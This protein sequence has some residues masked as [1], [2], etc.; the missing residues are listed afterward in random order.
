MHVNSLRAF[1]VTDAHS[2][3]CSSCC[4]VAFEYVR[5][6]GV[7][8][9]RLLRLPQNRGKVGHFWLWPNILRVCLKAST[10]VKCCITYEKQWQQQH[11]NSFT[12]HGG[13]KV[14][15]AIGSYILS[16]LGFEAFTLVTC[17]RTYEK[18]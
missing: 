2:C 11:N 8:A 7:D 9:V 6:H 10:S 3:R 4:R 16:L 15:Q 1:L 17:C 13:G 14:G 18:Q 12:K 5:K